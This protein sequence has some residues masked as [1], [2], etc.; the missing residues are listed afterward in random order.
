MNS[1]TRGNINE[2]FAAA[3][4]VLEREYRTGIVH[5]GYME[6]QVCAA[7]PDPMGI[8]TIYT[9]TQGPRTVH[10]DVSRLLDLPHT[11]V[12][13]VPMVIGGG[14]GGKHG[15]LEPLAAAV[16]LEMKAPVKLEL[17]RTEDFMTS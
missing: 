4:V 10:N 13:V 3:D 17:T 11:K 7:S 5:Q 14:F 15:M 8:M 12:K 1:Y 2:G 6:P 16:A 9:S